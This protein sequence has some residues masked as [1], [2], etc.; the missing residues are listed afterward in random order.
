MNVPIST[1]HKKTY[2]RN[3]EESIALYSLTMEIPSFAIELSGWV[4]AV[5]F[6]V[7]TAM[8]LIA[9]A[10]TR[11]TEGVSIA[12]WALFGIANVCLYI[13]TE[14]YF[15]PQAIIGMVG[16]ALMDLAIIVLVLILRRKRAS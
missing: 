11:K 12:A 7:G 1:L 4:P 10:R 16:A 8:Q 15:S 13:Y 2:S 14:K 6:P 9:I 3:N 5:I